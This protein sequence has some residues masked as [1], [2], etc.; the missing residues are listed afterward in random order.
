M[1]SPKGG[2]LLCQ[3]MPD[4]ILKCPDHPFHLPIGFTIAY[5]DVVVDNAQPFIEPCKAACKLGAIVCPDVARLAPT[6][7]QVIIQK[8]SCPLA[9]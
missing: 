1:V 2:G 9:V 4:T 8:L 5:S 3:A 6:G 7:N